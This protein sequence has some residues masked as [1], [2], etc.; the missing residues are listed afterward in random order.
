MEKKLAGIIVGKVKPSEYST[1][2]LKSSEGETIL[3]KIYSKDVDIDFDLD[4]N[5]LIKNINKLLIE[6]KNQIEQFENSTEEIENEKIINCL[7]GIITALEE[8]NLEAEKFII[9][10]KNFRV[11]SSEDIQLLSK[12]VL[13]GSLEDVTGLDLDNEENVE[14]DYVV[15]KNK[16]E[17][18]W[19]E[20]M[21]PVL[22][23]LNNFIGKYNESMVKYSVHTHGMVPPP[24]DGKEFTGYQD[25]NNDANNL[26]DL[27]SSKTTKTI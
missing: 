26:T 27:V 24:L 2:A 9:T 18:W 7:K 10:A 25:T 20:K 21:K 17:R 15:T 6:G 8:I 16:L 11:G 4:N 14:Y 12:E 19:G 3:I 1:V 22:A 13:L 5:V 23:Q